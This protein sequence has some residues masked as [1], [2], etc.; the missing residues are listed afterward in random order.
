MTSIVGSRFYK[1]M[2]ANLKGCLGT[3]TVTRSSSYPKSCKCHIRMLPFLSGGGRSN[4]PGP[5]H[6]LARELAINSRPR[7]ITFQQFWLLIKRP[8]VATYSAIFL[9]PVIYYSSAPDDE[10]NFMVEISLA[11]I[12]ASGHFFFFE[13]SH[14]KRRTQKGVSEGKPSVTRIL[15]WIPFP[16]SQG[17]IQF[18]SL[19]ISCEKWEMGCENS[20]FLFPVSDFSLLISCISHT[21]LFIQLTS[22]FLM[23][24]DNFIS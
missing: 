22:H 1:W 18:F 6:S 7:R 12:S 14:L 8:K 21:N 9:L 23:P 20:K 3:T 10:R 16:I 24:C 15:V 13:D 2:V 11:S 17:P 19:K 4:L 5:T